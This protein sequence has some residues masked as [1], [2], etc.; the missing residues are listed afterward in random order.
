MR[1]EMETMIIELVMSHPALSGL[2]TAF[3]VI[4]KIASIVDNNFDTQDWRG[5]KILNQKTA[6]LIRFLASNTKK[7]RLT[8]NS[9]IDEQ[10]KRELNIK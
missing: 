7:A 1:I 8:G 4:C 6:K 3:F 9:I 2:A 10:I 5:G